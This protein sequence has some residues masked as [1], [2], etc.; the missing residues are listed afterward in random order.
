MFL[1][2]YHLSIYR[3][4]TL[5]GANNVDHWLSLD[6]QEY[7]LQH[8][9]RLH[10][11]IAKHNWTVYATP[12][13][14]VLNE[15]GENLAAYRLKNGTIARIVTGCGEKLTLIMVDHGNTL[16]VSKKFALGGINRVSIGSGNDNDISYAFQELIS[17]N[18]C[19]LL[20]Q[21]SGLCVVDHSTNSTYCNGRKVRGT[22]LL[23]FGDQ[24]QIFGLL[25]VY[26]GSVLCLL[27]RGG[28]ARINAALLP[29]LQRA[30]DRIVNVPQPNHPA[31][32]FIN[33]SPRALP[34]I[35]R[36]TV[37]IEPVPD[38]HFAKQRPLLLTIGP[39]MTMALPMLLGC[40]L[41][42]YGMRASGSGGSAF[43]YTGLITAVGSAVLGVT[44]ALVNL[45]QS[46]KE[47]YAAERSRVSAYSNY[48]L[49]QAALLRTKYAQNAQA[50]AQTYPP[51]A[52]LCGYTA[53]T[54]QLWNRNP[55]HNDFLFQRLGLGDIPFQMPIEIPK[56][57]FTLTTDPLQEKSRELKSEFS[58]LH[59]APVGVDLLAESLIGVV[60]GPGK[61][62]ARPVVY[63]L[64]AGIAANNCYT[65]VK[66][67][68][69][70]ANS[71]RQTTRQWSFIQW[72][73]HVWNENRTTRYL[74]CG[75]TEAGDVFFDLCNILRS[76]VPDKDTATTTRPQPHPHYVLVVEDPALLDGEL[77]A[78]YV[79]AK[80]PALGL[81]T[82]LLSDACQNLPNSCE[83]I[84]E[85]DSF[86]SGYFHTLE[87]DRQAVRFDAVSTGQMEQLAHGLTALR[88][89][90]LE[91]GAEIPE[92]LEFLEMFGVHAMEELGITDRWRKSRTYTTMRVP[93]GRKAGSA[94]CY[95]DIHEK[96]HGPHGLIAG[97]TGSGKSETLQTYILSLALNFSPED[98]GFFIID[99]KG[100]GM[101]NL[102]RDL[103]HML[104]QISNLSGNQVR[105]AMIS[106]KSENRRRQRIFNEYGV[107]SINQYTRLYKN[108][109]SKQ[110]VPHLFIIIDEF[111]ELKREEPDFMRELISVAQVGRSLGVHLILA[112]QKP[113]GTV[114]D[115]IWSNS[116]FR[117]CLR[118]QD[119]QDSNDM[120]HKPD[121]A[122]ITQ[123][124]R[125]F[126]QVGN[127]EIYEQFQSA[128]SGAV[129]DANSGDGHASTAILLT[130]T[131]KA[132]ITGSRA[133]LRRR[134]REHLTWLTAVAQEVL[135]KVPAGPDANDEEQTG[136]LIGHLL[137]RPLLR[138][139]GLADNSTTRRALGSFLEL[140]PAGCAEALPAAEAIF[141][142]SETLNLA[143]P[144]PA[145]KTQLDALVGYLSQLAQAEHIHTGLKLWMPVLPT[146][147]ELR[148]LAGWQGHCFAAGQYPAM[149]DA[150]ELQTPL[151]LLDDPE[152][153]MQQPLCA[154]FAAGGHIAVCGSVFS[155]K[156]TLLQTLVYGLIMRYTP[157]WV[158]L[159]LLDFSSHMLSVFDGDPHIGAVLDESAPAQLGNFMCMLDNLMQDRKK[160]LKGGNYS[161][162]VRVH[163]VALPSVVIV[164]DNYTSFAEKTENRYEAIL[165]RAAREGVGFGVFL[166]LS[167]A[168]F[169]MSAIPNRIAENLKTVFCLSQPDKFKYME[170]LRC[171]GLAVQPEKGVAGRGLAVQ[172]NGPLEFQTALAVTAEDDYA[173]GRLLAA[174][175]AQI[176]AAWDG[177]AARP[178]PCIPAQPTFSALQTETDYAALRDDPACL[179][180]GYYQENAALY[181]IN[182]P[183][184]YCYSI[185]GRERSGR[186]NT[187][188][189]IMQAA[190]DKGAQLTVFEKDAARILPLA[191]KLG[192]RYLSTDAALFHYWQELT[193]EFVRRNKRKK[194]LENAG[195]TEAEIFEQMREEPLLCFFIPDLLSYLTAI[196]KPEPGAGEMR[197]FMETI[198]QNGALHN[199]YF[200]AC[201]RPDD[202]AALG[203]W[204]AFRLYTAK[205]SG[206]LLGGNPAAQRVFSFQNLPYAQLSKPLAK[207]IGLAANPT[208]DTQAEYV[209]IPLAER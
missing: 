164:I 149:P 119:R 167:G 180:I 144:F 172:Q 25:L 44:W 139:A 96:F 201:F 50:L 93:I 197:G 6:A 57:K 102:F 126:L 52:A 68:L 11:D 192:A 186:A 70:C 168:E 78:K 135:R 124:G 39:S 187:I 18:H 111:A 21:S 42:I 31:E 188:K 74:A 170:I 176:R 81:T 195:R 51:A 161:Q 115:N 2:L 72:L 15:A 165:L 127:D 30:A 54:P 196:Y 129:Y 101:A 128:W 177:P 204:Q 38:A 75:K 125:C 209:V 166:V 143:L 59:D 185:V 98:V 66:I 65:D 183:Q 9:I 20:R 95:L 100:G 56:E 103:P 206:V 203:A 1:M 171:T 61:A 189:L 49:Q 92:H 118:V 110:P 198:F 122:F 10:L 82:V 71:N 33:R 106:I 199:I 120:L 154:D 63:A 35:C 112:T 109:E 207:G 200:F 73:P 27:T 208:D 17:K 114:D 58:F 152:N 8:G 34:E 90:E 173:R 48:L 178:V 181:S 62:G 4:L 91:S 191:E 132:G 26:L 23:R 89:Q 202:N 60:G 83:F 134:E 190:A 108:G 146:M 43:M 77:I 137:R 158:N 140:W 150:W 142:K 184:T 94:L 45:R 99:F 155:G 153:Q 107:N 16:P 131:G 36:D 160:L 5:G 40:L 104:G 145:E 123:A 3:E 37:V 29:E 69:V 28:E 130:R 182:L 76:R 67:A 47:E 136:L 116:K 80:D 7:E 88:V 205:R 64:L 46:Q 24:L 32:L 87:D 113:S 84:I 13:Y 133:R 12:Q 157:A 194:A 174:E 156:S 41:A 169:G 138:Q 163:G 53:S 55:N 121:A 148:G 193:P 151:G 85:N 117:L 97:T 86:F 105:R 14:R 175:C 141:R 79:Y 162:Y 19:E 159:Y 147:L 179:P 22:Q